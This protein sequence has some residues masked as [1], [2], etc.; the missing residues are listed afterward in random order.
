MRYKKTWTQS[1]IWIFAVWEF[2]R[3][4]FICST[5]PEPCH[6][7]IQRGTWI[8]I[9]TKLANIKIES[10]SILVVK[11][12]C[13]NHW[14]ALFS[15]SWVLI[16]RH[17]DEIPFNQSIIYI[18]IKCYWNPRKIHSTPISMGFLQFQSYIHPIYLRIFPNFT[19]RGDRGRVGAMDLPELS[20]RATS[21][22]GHA[23]PLR[24]RSGLARWKSGK[25][26]PKKHEFQ[27][28]CQEKQMSFLCFFLVVFFWL[29]SIKLK[30]GNHGISMS[31][32]QKAHH[33]FWGEWHV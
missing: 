13:P 11:L 33:E 29:G 20:A 27:G 18:Y 6:G 14:Q 25:L 31:F 1:A 15:A 12:I 3:G 17:S 2:R 24:T 32:K 16:L 5:K 4:Y 9:P 30:A 23:P 22:E 21:C 26:P 28:N 7:P 8:T 10:M 19:W